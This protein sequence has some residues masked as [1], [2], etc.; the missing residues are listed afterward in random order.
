[1]QE[2]FLIIFLPL[3]V[4]EAGAACIFAA[5]HI[6]FGRAPRCIATSR[7]IWSGSAHFAATGGPISSGRL[8]PF[9]Y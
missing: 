8:R 5:S 9:I 4:V 1:M 3:L 7:Q 2:N 6:D